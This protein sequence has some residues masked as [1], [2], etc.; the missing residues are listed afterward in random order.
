MGC[1][2]HVVCY[3]LSAPFLFYRLERAHTSLFEQENIRA[4]RISTMTKA[5]RLEIFFSRMTVIL[6]VGIFFECDFNTYIWSSPLPPFPSPINRNFGGSVGKE[7]NE[8]YYYFPIPPLR[9]GVEK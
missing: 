8:L 7:T 2:P 3:D 6:R 5:F 9:F 1:S 4:P